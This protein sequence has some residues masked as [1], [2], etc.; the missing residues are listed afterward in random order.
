[1][2]EN[3]EPIDVYRIVA[4]VI[5]TFSEVAW[6]KMG[7]HPDPLTGRIEKDMVQAKVAI[8]LAG[9]CVDVLEPQLDDEDRRQLKNM[10]RDLRINYLQRSSEPA[11]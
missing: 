9:H 2:S 4:D 1:M 5:Q 7:L 11:G 6:A 3:P 10:I 8:D